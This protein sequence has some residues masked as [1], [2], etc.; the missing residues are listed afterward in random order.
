MPHEW[1][2]GA[3]A[4][5]V[6]VYPLA[7]PRLTLM[8]PSAHTDAPRCNEQVTVAGALPARDAAEWEVPA[9]LAKALSGSPLG[10]S[11]AGH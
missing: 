9:A 8:R 7:P 1:R 3:A 5:I 10:T 6:L 11:L 2:C 4:G